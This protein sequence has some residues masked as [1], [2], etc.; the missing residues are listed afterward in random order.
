MRTW[1]YTFSAVKTATGLAFKAR[2][3]FDRVVSTLGD[4]EEVIVTLTKPQ[5][6]RTNAQNRLAWGATYDQLIEALAD[7]VGYDRHDKDGKEKLHEALCIKYGGT[8]KD[9]LTGLAVRK[10]RTSKATKQQFTDYVEW[11]CR[12]AAQ[13]HGV[14]ITLPGEL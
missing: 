5:E 12:F 6:K 2:S 14:V 13:E 7:E 1:A 8:V 3:Y 10:F 4:G 9:P 11:I